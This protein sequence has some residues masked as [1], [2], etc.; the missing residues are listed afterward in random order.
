[1]HFQ[2]AHIPDECGHLMAQTFT[3]EYWQIC[4]RVPMY[5]E[6][7]EHCDMVPTYLQ[8]KRL[9]QLIGSN[10]PKTLDDQVPRPFEAFKVVLKSLSRC[11]DYMDPSRPRLSSLVLHQHEC[12]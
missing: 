5:N 1:M 8:H 10:E 3:D 2:A 4:S 12:N 6:W 9:L 11:L 7:Y